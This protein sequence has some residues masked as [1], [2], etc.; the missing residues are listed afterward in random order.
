MLRIGPA[1][2]PFDAS[3]DSSNIPYV[4]LELRPGPNRARGSRSRV[5]EKWILC[6]FP[7]DAASGAK[8]ISPRGVQAATRATIRNARRKSNLFTIIP[9]MFARATAADT[10]YTP[11][12]TMASARIGTVFAFSP[13]MFMRL[14]PTM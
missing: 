5:V 14:S 7:T 2:G 12:S 4:G 8:T 3:M 6:I 1:A 13:A 11:A 9:H 10:G